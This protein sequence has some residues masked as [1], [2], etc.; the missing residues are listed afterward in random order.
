VL[1]VFEADPLELPPLTVV[2]WLTVTSPLE[3]DCT[4]WFDTDT[5]LVVV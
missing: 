1:L 3:A 5:L 2:L 4:F